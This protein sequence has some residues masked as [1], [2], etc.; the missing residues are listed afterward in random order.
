MVL[1]LIVDW[2]KKN[3]KIIQEMIGISKDNKRHLIN[4][5]KILPGISLE[6]V[7]SHDNKTSRLM[8]KQNC[9]SMPEADD[10]VKTKL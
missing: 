3:T 7:Q 8:M 1:I 6:N 9:V 5:T 2:R 4:M 10:F